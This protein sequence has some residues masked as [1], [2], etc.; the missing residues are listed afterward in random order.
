MDRIWSFRCLAAGLVVVACVG[1]SAGRGDREIVSA[2]V[3]PELPGAGAAPARPLHAAP[4]PLV[5][6]PA[7][8]FRLASLA[9]RG[10]AA[11]RR[12]L[13]AADVAAVQPRPRSGPAAGDVAEIRDMLGSYLK[14]FNRHDAVAAAAH[15]SP[16]AEN[17]DLDT[18][19]VTAGREAVREVFATLFAEDSAAMIDV[20]VTSIRPVRADVAVV[21]GNSRVAFG[22]GAAAAS[23]F[24]A[25]VVKENGRWLLESVREAADPAA[26]A[27]ARPLDDLVWLVGMWEDV[28]PGLTA[29]TRCFWS[30]GRAFLI[31]TH[32]VTS[33]T[34]SDA[35]A[36]SGDD[37]IPGLL[38][39]AD[40][41]GREVTEIIGWDPERRE[42]R[43]WAFSSEG[44]FAEGVWTRDGD[45]WTVRLEG[46]GADTGRTSECTLVRRGSDEVS[47]RS[48]DDALA[49][50]FA[51]VS[52][53][54]RTAR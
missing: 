18:G 51:P 33:A 24:S 50:A 54:I 45:T 32:A 11:P 8:P 5:I 22:D 13:P 46:R 47:V 43:S 52:D 30:T 16:G 29:S 23:R 12:L 19:H 44:R 21:D 39:A 2:R 14:S 34:G 49:A 17:V 3:E 6:R 36:A 40:V 53:F 4:V 38:P 26:A 10:A 48:G 15:W 41:Q 42:I 20:D 28:G 27:A 1:C 31:R 37:R 9:T 35:P 25:V 7:R